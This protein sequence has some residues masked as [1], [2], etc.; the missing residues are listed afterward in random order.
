LLEG[1]NL[2]IEGLSLVRA[3]SGVLT[4]CPCIGIE[5]V[6]LFYAYPFYTFRTSKFCVS[7]VEG[8][9]L[10]Y[11]TQ[12]IS[13]LQKQIAPAVYSDLDLGITPERFRTELG[14]N[15]IIKGNRK[16]QAL[17][18]DPKKVEFFRQL[19]L[20]GDP[21][22]DA[23]AER[24][25][26]L[27]FKKVRAMLDQAAAHGVDTVKDAPSELVE[28]MKSVEQEPD[29]VDWDK[30]DYA[31]ENAR[32]MTAAAGEV[33]VRVAFMMTYVNGYQGLPMVITGA[34]TSESAAKRM[35]ETISTFKLA[36][37]P[38]A[39]KKGGAAYQSAVKVRVM[40]AMVRTNL[41]KRSKAWDYEV[42]GVP[43][44]QVDQ[45]GAALAFNYMASLRALKKNRPFNKYEAAAV[46]QSRYLAH[47]LGMHDQFLSND[48]KQI[49]ETW[50]MC[51]ATLRHKF[52][53][54]GK[55]LNSATINAYRRKNNG[56]YDR[57]FHKLDVNATQFMYTKIVGRR[58]S[59]TMGV[60]TQ[61]TD[62]LSF[63]AMFA[64]I[65]AG[66][67]ALLLLKKIPG[68]RGVIDSRAISEVNRQLEKE[69][70]AEYK[71]NERDYNGSTT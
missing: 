16:I 63:A 24:I 70:Q 66:F 11:S 35:K 68:L 20:M 34:L 49:V 2:A 41:L 33:I 28:L 29:W 55:D 3:Y 39:L 67:S 17:L 40:H 52:D 4:E 43:I 6:M 13:Q 1:L 31:S 36:T 37:L 69:G 57:L 47:L 21:L 38:G 26:E 51:Q 19:T 45:M 10:S 27:G 71:T 7:I 14:E 32:L 61:K 50:N 65:G 59:G 64:P 53:E 8:K 44:P 46:E 25:P 60:H 58:T 15:S 54:R 22:A 9:P 23:F 62:V 42:Y 18:D 5:K 56:W 48:P 12:N 30:I